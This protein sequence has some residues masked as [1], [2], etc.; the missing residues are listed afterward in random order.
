LN[1]K[2]Q[3]LVNEEIVGFIY[4]VASAHVLDCPA[5]GRAQRNKRRISM[6]NHTDGWMGGWMGGGIGGQMTIWVILAVLVVVVVVI[7]SLSRKK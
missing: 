3:D 1:S 6:M 7:K 5:G 4:G 2:D